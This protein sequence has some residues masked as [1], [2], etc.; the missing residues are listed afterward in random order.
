MRHLPTQTWV[1]AAYF[2]SR[3]LPGKGLRHGKPRAVKEPWT[4]ANSNTG[5]LQLADSLLEHPDRA[6]SSCGPLCPLLVARTVQCVALAACVPIEMPLKTRKGGHGQ[7]EEALL[8]PLSGA[9]PCFVIHT[10]SMWEA[11]QSFEDSWIE[12]GT[13]LRHRRI[14]SNVFKRFNNSCASSHTQPTCCGIPG[15]LKS[16]L[17]PQPYPASS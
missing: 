11:T 6:R 5:S 13:E 12:G 14:W 3:T 2:K 1:T 16:F 8:L 7:G 17:I 4:Q 10:K 9:E 15:T